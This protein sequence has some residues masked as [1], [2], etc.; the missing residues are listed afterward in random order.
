M[1]IGAL[2]VTVKGKLSASDG[3]L[4]FLGEVIAQLPMDCRL[5]KLIFLGYLLNVPEE[6]IIMGKHIIGILY[7]FFGFLKQLISSISI[8]FVRQ[9]IWDSYGSCVI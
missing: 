2:E 1:Q 6:C 9:I 3:D 8:E 7:R 4:T 5:G